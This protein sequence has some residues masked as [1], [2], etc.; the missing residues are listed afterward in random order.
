MHLNVRFCKYDVQNV[1]ID[2]PTF[3]FFVLYQKYYI[4]IKFVR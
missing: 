1:V 2:K 4:V 3:M